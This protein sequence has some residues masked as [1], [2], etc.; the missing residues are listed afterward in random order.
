MPAL[1]NYIDYSL[2]FHI[3][4]GNQCNCFYNFDNKTKGLYYRSIHSMETYKEDLGN[5]LDMMSKDLN[6]DLNK[7]KDDII[8]KI[9]KKDYKLTEDENHLGKHYIMEIDPEENVKMEIDIYEK[10]IIFDC[11]VSE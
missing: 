6:K 4:W 10:S 1:L 9:E 8:N 7:Y 5:D 11:S 3:F 2:T